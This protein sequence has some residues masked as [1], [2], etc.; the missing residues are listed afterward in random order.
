MIR[1]LFPAVY[2]FRQ[3]GQIEKDRQD[4]VKFKPI[5]VILRKLVEKKKRMDII[6]VFQINFA[7]NFIMVIFSF[8]ATLPWNS[9]IEL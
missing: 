1:Y 4:I 9:P 5:M 8:C 2:K 7:F 3:T 6:H